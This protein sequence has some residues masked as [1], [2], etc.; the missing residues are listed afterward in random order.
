MVDDKSVTSRAK[1]HYFAYIR[2]GGFCGRVAKKQ[3]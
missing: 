1:T 3:C 2:D